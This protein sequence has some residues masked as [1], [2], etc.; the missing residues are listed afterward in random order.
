MEP[1]KVIVLS[2]LLF[3]ITFLIVFL[4]AYVKR[5]NRAIKY[6]QVDVTDKQLIEYIN[7]Q[8]DKIVDTKML[9]EQFGL[10]KF[11]AGGRLRHMLNNGILRILRTRN[12]L[13]SYYT[14]LK[15]ID[16]EYSLDLTDDPFMTI[17]DLML[18]FKHYDYQVSIQEICLCTGLPLKVIN[19]EMKYFEKEN[20]VK[21]LLMTN[22]SGFGYQ[23]IYTLCEPYRSNPEE[24]LSLK[25]ANFE[26]KEIYKS[27]RGEN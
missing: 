4:I 24:Y 15:P 3:S 25:D 19:E 10:T 1:N 26:L 23:R 2:I 5:T 17:E 11:E 27:F 21:C 16:K 6:S 14:L 20:V 18:I 8:P 7:E 12:G 9:V 22:Q 13:K